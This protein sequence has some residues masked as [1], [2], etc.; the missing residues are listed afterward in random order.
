MYLA[1]D[2]FQSLVMG[3]GGKAL[4]AEAE[5]VLGRKLNESRMHNCCFV[6]W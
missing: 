6:H 1:N 2:N 4:I 5:H 3:V